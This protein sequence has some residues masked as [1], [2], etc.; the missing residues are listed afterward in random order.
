MIGTKGAFSIWLT[1]LA[2]IFVVALIYLIFNQVLYG[3]YGLVE[4]V[5]ASF[6]ETT[7]VNLTQPLSTMNIIQIV[8]NNWP[9]VAIFGILVWAFAKSASGGQREYP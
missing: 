3:S 9:I 2:S 7:N 8:W 1:A 5:N 4:T 6:N